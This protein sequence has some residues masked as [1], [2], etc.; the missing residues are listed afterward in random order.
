VSEREREG[1]REREEGGGREE[2]NLGKNSF[3][4]MYL[5]LHCTCIIHSFSYAV[6]KPN[7]CLVFHAGILQIV[8]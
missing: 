2:D 3:T 8:H 1:G 5:H 7:A 6:D 4:Y